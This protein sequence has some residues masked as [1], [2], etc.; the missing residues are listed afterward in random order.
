[1][2]FALSK[3]DV[4]FGYIAQFFSVSSGI[5]ILPLI[6]HT[7]TK[8]E[9]GLNYLLL[10]L[11]SL[12]S[13]FDFGFA[14]QFGRNI[15]YIFSGAQNLDKEGIDVA[16]DSK[17]INFNLLATILVT[18]KFVYRR[19]ATIV[20]LCMISFG[21]FYIYVVTNGFI[22]VDHSLLIW[23]IFSFST[24]FNIYYS[25]YNSFLLGKG[26]V[27]ES[28][29]ALLYSRII[30]IILSVLFLLLGFGLI[31][32]VIANLIAPFYNRFIS[33]NF[34]YTTELKAKL[35][36]YFVSNTEVLQL[37][38][39][40]WHNT[41]KL[42]LVFIST[43]ATNLIS[44]FLAG[45]YLP[46]TVTASYGLMIQMTGL[47]MIISRT[48]FDMYQPRFSSLR[49]L[50]EKDMLLKEFAFSMNVYYLLFIIGSFCL[51]FLGPWV[52]TLIDSNT[53]LPPFKTLLFFALI[54]F[55]EGNHSKF[56]AIIITSN[57]IPFVRSS[58][59]VCFFIALGSYISL[60]F[61]SL[62]IIGLVL[63]QGICQLVYSNWKWP[64]F[65]CKQFGISF[66]SF[67][68]IGCEETIIRFKLFLK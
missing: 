64:Y 10:T 48:L 25:Y 1:M 7:L 33:Y 47:V 56:S 15:S 46:L 63:V 22:K 45:L 29:K 44:L 30:Y 67:V 4:I 5:F 65:V 24:F 40:L 34:F 13:L 37:F 43:N 57:T 19:I 49:I 39:I 41:K 18:A 9:I 8:E 61:T 12:V 59:I 42:G 32:I 11:G 66:I 54:V 38:H 14:Q 26:L 2:K 6:L 68:L 20:L 58:L 17:N 53:Q 35:N 31:G 28:K 55:L 23:I 51:A 27:L 36:T 62:E 21:T 3:K 52:L 60:R 16:I 50:G